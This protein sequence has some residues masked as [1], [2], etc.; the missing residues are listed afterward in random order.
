MNDTEKNLLEAFSNY[1]YTEPIQYTYRIYYNDSTGDCLYSDVVLHNDP[2]I[3]VDR[4]TFDVFNPAL[5][6]V[7]S[8]RL[9]PKQVDYTDKRIL[10][11]GDGAYKTIKG[12]SM[13]LVDDNY[14]GETTP[15]K[16]NDD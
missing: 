6:R 5:Y 14:V 10:T 16:Q 9:K 1:K 13:F 4:T 8:G 15:W 3:E 11:I 2:Y 12:S 7:V